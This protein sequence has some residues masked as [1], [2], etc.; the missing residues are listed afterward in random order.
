MRTP[1]PYQQRYANHQWTNS[2]QRLFIAGFIAVLISAI[3]SYSV[4]T[5]STTD[6][7]HTGWI[8]VSL[9]GAMSGSLWVEAR[10]R[11]QKDRV[12]W[13]PPARPR[14]GQYDSM[15][16]PIRIR[17]GHN[18]HLG[19]NSDVSTVRLRTK[20]VST[21]RSELNSV[22]RDTVHRPHRAQE[23][24]IVEVEP[25]TS[26]PETGPR[27]DNSSPGTVEPASHAATILRI[28]RKEPHASGVLD[29][30][31]PVQ[32][33]G[34]FIFQPFRSDSEPSATKALPCESATDLIIGDRA[35]Q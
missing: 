27:F 9:A 29:P 24:P 6:Q 10:R 34:S 11:G 1:H 2:R 25:L 19:S 33:A 12:R 14:Q 18:C 8:A 4:A 23:L 13:S 20:P 3:I 26:R 31:I 28:Y 15:V 17:R 35:L 21:I 16:V 5:Y 32:P 22:D 30:L 7:L